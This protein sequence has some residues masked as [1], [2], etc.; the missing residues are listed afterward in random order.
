MLLLAS[1]RRGASSTILLIS[2][3][4]VFGITDYHYFTHPAKLNFKKLAEYV[5]QTKNEEDFLINWNAGSHHLWETK[6]YGFPAPIYVQGEGDLPFFVGTALME[7]GDVVREIPQNTDRVGVITSG[8]LEEV[9]LEDFER[10]EEK[11]IGKLKFVWLE[12]K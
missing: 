12:R 2:V 7:E 3:M 1:G 8:S 9:S 5:N 4:V 6:Y 11:A 10:A